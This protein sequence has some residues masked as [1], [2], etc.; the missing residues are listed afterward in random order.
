MQIIV[1]PGCSAR[2][3]IKT[4]AAGKFACPK[5]Q[6]VL[7]FQA[8]AEQPLAESTEPV[9]SPPAEQ[10]DF[11]AQ[12]PPVV[13]APET[14]SNYAGQ[15]TGSYSVKNSG[16]HSNASRDAYGT[17]KA[18]SRSVTLADPITKGYLKKLGLGLAVLCGVVLLSMPLLAFPDSPVCLVPICLLA[19]SVLVLVLWGRIW[20]VVLGFNQSVAQGFL[21]MLVP[22][23][24]L[25]FLVRNKQACVRPLVTMG[26]AL[27]PGLF[28]L[29]IDTFFRPDF[30]HEGGGS[31][32]LRLSSSQYSRITKDLAEAAKLAGPSDVVTAKFNVFTSPRGFDV[33][34][35]ERA[36]ARLPGYIPGSFQMAPDN[37]SLSLQYRG[38]RRDLAMRYAIV[39]PGE[40]GIMVDL[41]PNFD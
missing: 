23:Y 9:M 14:Q 27:V 8:R 35:A 24:W 5:C 32:S 22:Y 16:G 11:L 34:A 19:L 13:P 36:L 17:S 21:V 29:V 15:R 4:G 1:C 33:V 12:L 3:K 25:F 40:S 7:R 6:K 2:I 31:S 26:A 20:F 18:T 10:N 38:T 39:L 30:L 41:N 37:K 28:G